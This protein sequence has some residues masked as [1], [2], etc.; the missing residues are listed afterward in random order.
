MILGMPVARSDHR[1]RCG[2]ETVN[3]PIQPLKELVAVRNGKG[4]PR[5]KIV[6][7]IHD[8]QRVAR[9]RIELAERHH[10]RESALSL[11]CRNHWSMTTCRENHCFISSCLATACSQAAGSQPRT[12]LWGGFPSRARS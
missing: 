4:S 7:H 11:L 3:V 2:T 1:Q 6:L 8:Q 10:E 9:S 5:Q 12:F